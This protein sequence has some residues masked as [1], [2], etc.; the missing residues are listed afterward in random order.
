VERPVTSER[1]RRTVRRAV[2]FAVAGSARDLDLLGDLVWA[3]FLTTD[4]VARLHF[5]SRRRAQ[6]RL[7]ALLDL[8]LVRAHLQGEALHRENVHTLTPAG[9]ELLLEHGRF[10]AATPPRL[11]RLPRLQK[12]RHAIAIRE[13][14]VAFRLAEATNAFDLEDF[15]FEEQLAAMPPFAAHELVPDALAIVNAPKK[16]TIGIEIDLGTETTGVVRH[17]LERWRRAIAAD[18]ASA[19]V[20]ATDR[21]KRGATIDR[22]ARDV[23][24]SGR[25]HVVLLTDLQTWVA[26]KGWARPLSAGPVLTARTAPRPEGREM[27]GIVRRRGLGV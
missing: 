23:G 25:A 13:A 27:T 24:F 26:T 6:R 9:L 17:K 22:L 7:R 1:T 20:V 18:A 5:P 8:S 19:L 21:E 14:F 12:L 16:A 11:G 15:L 3:G 4:Q 10:D 2:T